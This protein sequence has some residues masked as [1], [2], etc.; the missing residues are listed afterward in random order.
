MGAALFAEYESL[1]TREP[2]FER[3]VLDSGERDALL[4]AF[5]SVCGWTRVYYLWRPNLPDEA[6]NHVLELAVAG[7]AEVI[8]TKNVRDFVRSELLFPEIRIMKPEQLNLE[9]TP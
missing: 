1:M 8:V 9:A 3:C 2:L 4:N 7:R 5:L 6:D